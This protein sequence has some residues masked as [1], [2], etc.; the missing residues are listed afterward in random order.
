MIK[1]MPN[2]LIICYQL[3]IK[4]L[5]FIPGDAEMVG[6]ANVSSLQK[7]KLVKELTSLDADYIIID[8]GAGS[9]FNTIDFFML[10]TFGIIVATPEITSILNAYAFLKNSIFRLMQAGLKK[11]KEVNAIFSKHLIKGG[12]AAW[13]V[14]EFNG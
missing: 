13:K 3:I 7:K 11:Y 2:L 8:L 12:E 5:N 10:S 9:A 6:I 14:A 1:K 4:D